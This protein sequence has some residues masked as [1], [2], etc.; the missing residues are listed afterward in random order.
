VDCHLRC[1]FRHDINHKVQELTVNRDRCLLCVL[2]W[3][4][5][6]LKRFSTMPFVF[7]D[8]TDVCNYASRNDKS[9]WLSTTA[10]LPMMPVEG[11][12]ISEYISRCTVCDVPANAV[13]FHSQTT[14]IPDCPHGWT[15]LWIGYSFVMVKTSVFF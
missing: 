13:A 3:P 10:S 8:F 12:E 11:R 9:Y 5:S 7:C 4:G 6:C 1:I 2:G 14:D 15:G